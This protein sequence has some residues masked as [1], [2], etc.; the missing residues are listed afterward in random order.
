MPRAAIS[1]LHKNSALSK[2]SVMFKNAALIGE[3]A[4]PTVKVTKKNDFYYVYGTENF[5]L[6]QDIKA[7]KAYANKVT[8]TVATGNYFCLEHA[9]EDVVTPG[10]MAN[11]DAPLSP[12]VDATEMVT[13]RILLR[14]EKESADL[15]FGTSN[16]AAARRSSTGLPYWNG[17]SGNCIEQMASA[18]DQI[19]LASGKIPNQLVLGGAT[20]TGLQTN[21]VLNDRIKFT[22]GG[23]I[24][25]EI[26]AGLF[27][28]EKVLV[29][30]AVYN[31]A[32]EGQTASN[33]A[34]WGDYAAL[35]Y[36]ERSPGVRKA[37][38]AYRFA[39]KDRMVETREDAGIAKG[40]T[41]VRV[42][43]SYDTKKISDTCGY[44]FLNCV[45]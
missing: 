19:I 30:R 37:S 22:Q 43:D 38:F 41:W 25:P 5:N 13:D 39:D 21:T 2:I 4:V 28:V 6:E 8:Y 23:V 16:Y 7:D 1:D 11:A 15:I 29:G 31:S 24:G 3:E 14:K 35:T 9:L 45:Q 26:M 10:M 27:E 33:A 42:I 44:L 12:L 40:A 36:T 17:S 18:R 32:N 34:L 20:Y